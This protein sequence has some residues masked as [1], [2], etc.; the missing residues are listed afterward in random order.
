MLKEVRDKKKTTEYD[1][2]RDFNQY[3]LSRI[4]GNSWLNKY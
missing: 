3:C 2:A 4:R 1:Y